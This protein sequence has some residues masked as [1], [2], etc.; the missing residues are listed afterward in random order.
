MA[1]YVHVCKNDNTMIMLTTNAT[2]GGGFFKCNDY[3]WLVCNYTGGDD[4]TLGCDV[5]MDGKNWAQSNSEQLWQVQPNAN[6]RGFQLINVNAKS[7]NS[8]SCGSNCGPGN[9][10]PNVSMNGQKVKIYTWEYAI[11]GCV[12]DNDSDSDSGS[13]SGSD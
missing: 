2:S 12:S 6:G 9:D 3:N 8:G 13:D 7:K 5:K 4:K 1:L 10:G 11:G